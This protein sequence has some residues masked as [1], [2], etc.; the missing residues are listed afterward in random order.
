VNKFTIGDIESL[1]GIKTQTIR[2][3][4]QRY[5]LLATKRT[6]TNIRYYDDDDLCYFLNVVT[7]LNSGHKISAVAAM[8]PKEIAEKVTGTDLQDNQSMLISRLVAATIRLDEKEINSTLDNCIKA[9]GLISA[10]NQTIFPFMVKIGLMWQVGTLNPAHEHFAT[11]LIR[12]K[13]ITAISALPDQLTEHP[14]KFLLFLPPGET[15]DTGLLMAHYLLKKER[16]HVLYLGQDVPYYVLHETASYYQPSFA[17]TALTLAKHETP[18][19]IVQQLLINLPH[20]PLVVSGPLA[21]DT[22]IEPQERLTL[23]KNFDEFELLV[24]NTAQK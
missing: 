5:N 10:A 13:I 2:K 15:H 17:I 1:T 16:Q 8:T 20:W 6:A 7:L 14:K 11:N 12:H 9:T 4:E 21:A 24:K 22:Q 23:I 19:Q 3:W 18:S